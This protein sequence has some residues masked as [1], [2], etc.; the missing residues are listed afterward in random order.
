MNK[1]LPYIISNAG[2]ILLFAGAFR[3]PRTVRWLF[4]T[5]FFLASWV[6]WTLCMFQPAVYLEFAKTNVLPLYATF[7]KGWFSAHIPLVVGLIA[8]GQGLIAG[9]LLFKGLLFRLGCTAAIIF[10]I[11]I[12]PLGIGSA[13]PAPAVLAAAITV[14]W[15]RG[16]SF[17]AS[18]HHEKQIYFSSHID[19]I[20]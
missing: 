9:L 8:T 19:K 11:A 7:I 12:L 2:A 4:I 13:S 15:I 3:R 18:A 6:N 10:F 1:I 20:I 5:M 16:N 17:N 14:L